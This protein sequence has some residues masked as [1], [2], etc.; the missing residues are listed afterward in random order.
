LG[1]NGVLISANDHECS[2]CTHKYKEIADV[3][4]DAND[5]A[6]GTVG[7]EEEERLLGVVEGQ[8]EAEQHAAED[9]ETALVKMVVV[10]GIVMGHTV[11]T[12]NKVSINVLLM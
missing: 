3:I 12:F 4:V 9:D 7:M 5:N 2:E 8:T 6:A 1:D 11:S 10:D